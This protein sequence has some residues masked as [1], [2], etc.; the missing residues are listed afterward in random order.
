MTGS[1][2]VSLF[3]SGLLSLFTWCHFFC[4]YVPLCQYMRTGRSAP[5]SCSSYLGNTIEVQSLWATVQHW[6]S[7]SQELLCNGQTQQLAYTHVCFIWQ[8]SPSPFSRLRAYAPQVRRAM[9]QR[10][11]ARPYAWE[12]SSSLQRFPPFKSLLK[13]HLSLTRV[14]N[15]R[16]II[17][18]QVESYLGMAWIRAVQL[19]DDS[20]SAVHRFPLQC[21]P[22]TRVEGLMALSWASAM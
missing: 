16:R 3:E 2:K 18:Q 8:K 22:Q 21:I 19:E 15:Y 12:V 4:P 5:L 14:L 1:P 17:A 6:W 9:N 7:S 13:T 11:S 10:A 20:G